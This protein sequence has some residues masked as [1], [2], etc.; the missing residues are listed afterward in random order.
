MFAR[1]FLLSS[2]VSRPWSAATAVCKCV[3]VCPRRAG[4]DYHSAVSLDGVCPK[5]VAPRGDYCIVFSPATF[6]YP[7]PLV[8]LVVFSFVR[9][10]VRILAI[11]NICCGYSCWCWVFLGCCCEF[12][13]LT[14]LLVINC[15]AQ[16]WS[17]MGYGVGK[18]MHVS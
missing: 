2:L 9:W 10:F 5:V 1:F 16:K 14:V 12:C 8:G 4:F 3:F 15:Q 18:E 6:R 7:S 13:L 11:Y 17:S